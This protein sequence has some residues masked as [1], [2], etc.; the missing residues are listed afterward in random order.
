MTH[1]LDLGK[2]FSGSEQELSSHIVWA[3]ILYPAPIYCAPWGVYTT[4][5]YTCFLIY[6]RARVPVSMLDDCYDNSLIVHKKL[7]GDWHAENT[8]KG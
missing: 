7:E 2:W 5:F 1:F 3:Q 6:K 8:Q 4:F